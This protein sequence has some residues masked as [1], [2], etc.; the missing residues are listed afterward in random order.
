MRCAGLFLIVQPDKAVLLCA[1]R[2]YCGHIKLTPA[3]ADVAANCSG[4]LQRI[5]FLEKISIPRGK[6]DGR[7]I[8]DYETA[9]REF[10]EET[11]CFFENAYVHRAPFLLHWKDNGVTYTYS[12]YVGVTISAALKQMAREPNSFCV[13]L[14]RGRAAATTG[15][16]SS[17]SSSN[18]YRINIEKRRYNNE[19][20]RR[21]YILPLDDYFQ[22]MN[23][24]QLITYDSS[25]YLDFFTYVRNVKREFDSGR[26][27]S[28]FWLSLELDCGE[29]RASE[30]VVN[31]SSTNTN[32]WPTFRPNF[33]TATRNALRE[34]GTIV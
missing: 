33:V 16:N 24:K 29:R 13:K 26:L 12:I 1:N 22:Y 20:S 34:I 14:N 7:D 8:F 15:D 28:F 30:A 2:S 21:L 10:I 4:T 17:S 19:I 18:I 3:A 31:N 27:G 11:G 23:D 9:V 25:N 5:S 6:R 32:K